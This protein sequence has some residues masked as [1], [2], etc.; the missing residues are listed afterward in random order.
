MERAPTGLFNE[1]V[2]RPAL[3]KFGAVT[4]LTITLYDADEQI[5]CG[6]VPPTPLAAVFQEHGSGLDL[7]AQCA[8]QCLAEADTR[9]AVVVAPTGCLAVVGTCLRLRDEI[10]AAAVAGYAL[11]D[12]CQSATIE[13]LARQTRVPFRRLSEVV[14]RQQPVPERRL[15]LQ[16]ELLQVLGDTLLRENDRTRQHEETAAELTATAAVKDEFLAVLSHELRTPLTPILGWARM[17]R[18]DSDPAQIARAAQSIER[19]A[20]LQVRL[21]EDL[22]ELTRVARGKV[23]L[24]VKVLDLGRAIRAAVDSIADASQN[25]HVAVTIVDTDEPLLVEADTDR[26]QQ[27]F[28]NVLANAVKFTP[29]GG[30]INVVSTREGT[31]AVVKIRDS[32]EGIAPEFLPFVFDIF[33]QQEEGT[34]R[35]HPGLGIGLALVKRLTELQHGV[36]TIASGGIGT[37]AEVTLRFPLASE[38]QE[39]DPVVASSLNLQR[40]LEGLRILVVEDIEDS[41]D[42]IQMMLEHLGAEVFVA[43]DGVEALEAVERHD[44][45]VV[46]CD[47]RMPRMDGFEFIRQVH[48]TAGRRNLPVIAI[49]GLTSSADRQRTEAAGFEGHINKPFD[50]VALVAAVG[51][52]ID[53]RQSE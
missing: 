13:R 28:R 39:P 11:L 22:L 40:E 8:R 27:I 17:L 49:S 26:I 7:F 9:P 10:V 21:V 53:R 44:P 16:G 51:A 19:N 46:L 33:R 15:I 24:D 36:V 43:E 42:A 41:R 52:V 30:S 50:D 45:D 20:L 35:A 31:Q 12:F 6:P 23:S 25:K 14:R 2:W 37:G 4:Q 47:L 18:R 29:A 1:D 48:A 34:R 3:A 32:G 38:G 5:V